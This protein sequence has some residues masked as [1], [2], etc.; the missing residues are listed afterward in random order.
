MRLFDGH[1]SYEDLLSAMNSDISGYIGKPSRAKRIAAAATS[2]KVIVPK[3][4]RAVIQAS[5][6]AGTTLRNTPGGILLL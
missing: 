5:G 2:A 1:I 6:A 3:R 4:S